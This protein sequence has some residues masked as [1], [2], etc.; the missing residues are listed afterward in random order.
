M[1]MDLNATNHKSFISS[2]SATIRVNSLMN[3]D[4]TRGGFRILVRGGVNVLF[5]GA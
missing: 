1:F 3:M 4:M 2:S 5:E